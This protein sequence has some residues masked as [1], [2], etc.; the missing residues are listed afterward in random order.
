VSAEP[1]AKQ[2]Q[3]VMQVHLEPNRV[4]DGDLSYCWA[5]IATTFIERDPRYVLGAMQDVK[6]IEKTTLRI[7]VD[8]AIW[9]ATYPSPDLL[10]KN[11]TPNGKMFTNSIIAEAVQMTLQ[12][13]KLRDSTRAEVGPADAWKFQY[14]PNTKVLDLSKLV[15]PWAVSGKSA[16]PSIKSVCFVLDVSGSMAGGRIARTKENMLMVFD[17]YVNS[18]D[19][20]AYIEFNKQVYTKVP[21][22]TKS[23][24][25]RQA[26]ERAKAG[27]GTNFYDAMITAVNQLGEANGNRK[28]YIIALTDGA[29]GSS[30]ATVQ[31][32]CDR[33]QVHEEIT[34]FII[35]AG[36]DIP[37]ADVQIMQRMVGEEIGPY[38]AVPSIG[39]MYVKAEKT[40]DLEAAF[41]SVAAAMNDCEMEQL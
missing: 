32:V 29:N 41:E 25:H 1:I 26:M 20:V 6:T 15:P 40:E 9:F 34:P 30:Q 7:L 3:R 27:G 11:E 36:G 13:Y 35:G 18:A 21:M 22:K 38:R 17:K 39:G 12:S 10:L 23:D 8:S 28:K 33:L 24:E 14:H 5:S 37:S 4:V 19:E 2:L 16:G 31:D